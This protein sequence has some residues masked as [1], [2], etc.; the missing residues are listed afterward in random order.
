MHKQKLQEHDIEVEL[1]KYV[2][3]LLASVC[4]YLLTTLRFLAD[5]NVFGVQEGK[6]GNLG[7]FQPFLL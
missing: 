7:H 3:K 4:V 5:C 2:C 1:C 6:C